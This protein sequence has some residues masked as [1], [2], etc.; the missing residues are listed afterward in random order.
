MATSTLF[1]LAGRATAAL[2]LTVAGALLATCLFCWHWQRFSVREAPPAF[3]HAGP[4]VQQL[5]RLQYLVSERVHL[6]DV[7]VGETRWLKG[8]WIVQGDALIAVDM[9]QADITAKDDRSRTA[10]ICL[11]TPVVLSARVNHEKTRKWDIRSTSW[12]PLASLILGNREQLEQEAMREAQQL[13]ERAAAAPEH[14][15]LARRDCEIALREF[16][17]QVDWQ[18]QIDWK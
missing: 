2:L 1:R 5:E 11:P 13:V 12:I 10:T 7:L 16:Y 4:T 14:I 18:V 9:S 15:E 17:R 6:A 8:S 3:A